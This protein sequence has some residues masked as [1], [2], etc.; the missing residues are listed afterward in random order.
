M[1]RTLQVCLL[2]DL[3]RLGLFLERAEY[4]QQDICENYFHEDNSKTERGRFLIIHEHDRNRV[5]A[6]IVQ[7]Y[8][9]Q[10][11]TQLHEISA[12]VERDEDGDAAE[13]V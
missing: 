9:F 13:A 3:M 8:L 12:F 2:D 11:R 10:M 5:R 6:D 7:D 1:T 4:T